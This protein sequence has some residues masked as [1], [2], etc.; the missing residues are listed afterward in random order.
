MVMPVCDTP[1]NLKEQK[2]Q[3]LFAEHVMPTFAST[4][5]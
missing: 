4:S 3:E 5:N 2:K 1:S